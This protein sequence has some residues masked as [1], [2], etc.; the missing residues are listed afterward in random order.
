[1]YS[2]QRIDKGT[3]G[4]GNKRSNGHHPNDSIIKIGQNTTSLGD[5]RRL[6]GVKNSEKIRI[7]IIIDWSVPV[8]NNISVKGKE[9][10]KIIKYKEL[11][12]ENEKMWYLKTTTVPVVDV[13]LVM[14]KKGTN[15]HINKIPISLSLYEI[16]K[17]H[18]RNCSSF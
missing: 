2:H 16:Q 7:I 14:I 10:D 9:Y 1:M 8:T 12:I 11:N 15:K 5:L 4:L 17:V 3:G 18:L 13:T 6:P